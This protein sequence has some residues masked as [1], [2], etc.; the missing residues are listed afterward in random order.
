MRFMTFYLLLMHLFAIYD[1]LPTTYA[2]I[3]IFDS[4]F[5]FL[6]LV[7]KDHK[8]LDFIR[9]GCKIF[10]ACYFVCACYCFWLLFFVLASFNFDSCFYA[11][12][13]YPYS[14]IGL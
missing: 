7:C 3:F 4:C 13:F 1:I 9:W 14:N 10:N 2:F 5:K 8:I 11:V 6:I 12:F